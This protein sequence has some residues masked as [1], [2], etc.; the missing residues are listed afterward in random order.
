MFDEVM[1]E[2][3]GREQ[4]KMR[5][6]VVNRTGHQTVA[7]QK[8]GRH[9]AFLCGRG[10]RMGQAARRTPNFPRMYY[11]TVLGTGW[12]YPA[13]PYSYLLTSSYNFATGKALHQA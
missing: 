7:V 8:E 4:K 13:Y 11:S 10:E 5:D 9:R 6:R 3:V 2:E 1:E 12:H